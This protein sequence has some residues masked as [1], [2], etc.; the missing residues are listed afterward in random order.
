MEGGWGEK[1]WGEVMPGPWQV[2][3]CSIEEEKGEGPSDS[4]GLVPLLHPGLSSNPTGS[5]KAGTQAGLHSGPSVM[6]CFES[7]S[8]GLVILSV[9]V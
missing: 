5:L 1:G 7:G 8:P 2:G 4:L 6:G 3:G 9:P